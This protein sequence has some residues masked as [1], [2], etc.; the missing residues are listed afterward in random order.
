VVTPRNAEVT[1][2][3]VEVTPRNAE[4]TPKNDVSKNL[5]SIAK[6]KFHEHQTTSKQ[7]IYVNHTNN[8]F[9]M[10][11]Q[12]VGCGG[13]D[14]MELA[15]DRDSWRG[16]VNAVINLRVSFNAENFLTS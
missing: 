8:P 10:D 7:T 1:P 2:R 4:V 14:W 11:L 3:N 9:S 5:P 6:I 16:L 12:E 13:M 15:Q